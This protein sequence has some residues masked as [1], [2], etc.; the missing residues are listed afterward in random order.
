MPNE[1]SKKDEI[2]LEKEIKKATFIF[3]ELH[4]SGLDY[5]S[6]EK[7][8]WGDLYRCNYYRGFYVV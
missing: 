3:N 1:L 5:E 6:A 8:A 4:S 2:D 7:L